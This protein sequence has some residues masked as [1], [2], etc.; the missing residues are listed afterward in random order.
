VAKDT[1]KNAMIDPKNTRVVRVETTGLSKRYPY[2][3]KNSRMKKELEIMLALFLSFI[4]N[5]VAAIT[6][7]AKPR[8][9]A[10]NMKS[11]RNEV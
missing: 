5:F 10:I 4:V 1:A 11:V 7:M 6:R 3:K 2:G 9:P 8:V